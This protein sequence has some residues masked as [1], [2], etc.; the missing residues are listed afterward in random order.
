MR[1]GCQTPLSSRSLYS[2]C[3][4]VVNSSNLGC[5]TIDFAVMFPAL[6]AYTDGV[7]FCT[8]TPKSSTTVAY[9]C[10]TVAWWMISGSTDTAAQSAAARMTN[11]DLHN[12]GKDGVLA[13][14]VVE[15]AAIS[16]E[17]M[18]VTG[19]LMSLTT[20]ERLV[21]CRRLHWWQYCVE[22][23]SVN[24]VKAFVFWKVYS[25]GLVG[26]FVNNAIVVRFTVFDSALLVQFEHFFS[27]WITL[28]L[29]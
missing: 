19:L 28:F 8:V 23:V 5:L 25:D 3:P 27:N 1:V 10:A 20:V 29:G 22:V 7:M 24:N 18:V 13:F 6:R 14:I 16:S 4:A 2:P 21:G 26:N 15:A 12:F 17:I 11:G 9:S